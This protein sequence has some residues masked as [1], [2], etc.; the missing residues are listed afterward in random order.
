MKQRMIQQKVG[1]RAKA[2]IPLT[3]MAYDVI[4]N[5]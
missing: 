4:R 3:T 5:R 1:T 2:C